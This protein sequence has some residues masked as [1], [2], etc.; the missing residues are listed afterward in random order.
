MARLDMRGRLAR[1]PDGKQRAGAGRGRRLAGR[2]GALLAA[3]LA[4]GGCGAEEPAAARAPASVPADFPPEELSSF[5]QHPQ[6]LMVLSR[7]RGLVAVREGVDDGQALALFEAHGA[8]VVAHKPELGV[9][10]VE[11]PD[12][13]D[14]SAIDALLAALGGAG[15]IEAAAHVPLLGP[16]GTPGPVGT[17][18]PWRYSGIFFDSPKGPAGPMLSGSPAWAIE[19]ARVP[20]AWNLRDY[21][22]RAGKT[23]GTVWVVDQGFPA[24]EEVPIDRYPLAADAPIDHGTLVGSVIGAKWGNGKAIDGLLPAPVHMVGATFAAWPGPLTGVFSDAF[25]VL[26]GALKQYA[27]P[28][29]QVVSWSSGYNWYAGKGDP[30]DPAGMDG[31]RDD[32]RL[33]IAGQAAVFAKLVLRWLKQLPGLVVVVS[34]GN[35][36]GGKDVALEGKIYPGFPGGLS[37][38]ATSPMAYA[39]VHGFIPNGIVVGSATRTG[40]LGIAAHSNR[41]PSVFAGGVGIGAVTLQDGQATTGAAHGTSL[42]TPIVAGTAAL[43]Q[44]LAPGRSYSA[45]RDAI[46]ASG[47]PFAGL[48]PLFGNVPVLDAFGAAMALDDPKSMPLQVALV[49]TDDGTADGCRRVARG[50]DGAALGTVTTDERGDGVVDMRD[51][52]RFRDAYLL[53]YH[54]GAGLDGLDKS[55]EGE[56]TGMPAKMDLNGDG[57]LSPSPPAQYVPPGTKAMRGENVWS[58]F[59]FNGDGVL[60]RDWT[61]LFKGKPTTD[62]GVLVAAWGKSNASAKRQPDLEG[63]NEPSLDGL[64]ALLVSADVEVRVERMFADEAMKKVDEIEVHVWRSGEAEPGP[65]EPGPRVRRM[66]RSAPSHSVVVTAL[67]LGPVGTKRTLR[68]RAYY[69]PAGGKPA[70]AEVTPGTASPQLD[71][72]KFTASIV[73]AQAGEDRVAVFGPKPKPAGESIVYADLEGAEP[74]LWLA[75]PAGLSPPLDLLQGIEPKQVFGGWSCSPTGKHVGYRVDDQLRIYRANGT[76]LS[77]AIPPAAAGSPLLS[78]DGSRLVWIEKAGSGTKVVVAPTGDGEPQSFTLAA[79]QADPASLSLS[80]DGGSLLVG[81]PS[82][83]G[84]GNMSPGGAQPGPPHDLVMSLKSGATSALY[85]KVIGVTFPGGIGVGK[86]RVRIFGGA[87][88]PSGDVIFSSDEAQLLE[89]KATLESLGADPLDPKALGE[90]YRVF[91]GGSQAEQLTSLSGGSPDIPALSPSGERALY[92]FQNLSPV[93]GELR[94]LTVASSTVAVLDQAIAAQ[95]RVCWLATEP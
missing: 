71:D 65:G 13:G 51:F 29:V 57:K 62:L 20:A 10:L 38:A 41:P 66:K 12:P 21:L 84:M 59:D 56:P 9:W 7:A 40:S 58:R 14:H 23:E 28:G 5:S 2:A 73:D 60:H 45:Y 42:A 81:D 94:L 31:I 44:M 33:E 72:D 67:L 3:A 87:F 37:P 69:L 32:I 61:M 8:R 26:G 74:R 18:E 27:G 83:Q 39:A 11:V 92:W 90:L 35:D 25:D 34:A 85:D 82:S 19:L 50:D 75:D 68:A 93:Q 52:R 89:F 55:A 49:D 64:Q 63:W 4:L 1:R 30:R 16:H 48:G 70:A 78:D 6:L 43:L 53:A 15:E 77:F 79:F 24:T 47:L 22:A 17:S 76:S 88:T 54:D 80:P 46:L 91:A 86:Q 36:G 95:G